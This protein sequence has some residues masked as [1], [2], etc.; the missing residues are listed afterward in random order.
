MQTL[1]ITFTK[2][3][4]LKKHWHN[5]IWAKFYLGEVAENFN[6]QVL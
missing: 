6:S 5:W 3:F 1:T 2:L 4:L